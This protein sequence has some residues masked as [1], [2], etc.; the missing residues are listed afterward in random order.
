M[1]EILVILR[2][3]VVEILQIIGFAF[4]IP[5]HENCVICLHHP[6]VHLPLLPHYSQ[7]FLR[8][9]IYFI[10]TSDSSFTYIFCFYIFSYSAYAFQPSQL[11]LCSTIPTGFTFSY[12]VAMTC[13]TLGLFVIILSIYIKNLISVVVVLLLLRLAIANYSLP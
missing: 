7:A 13:L 8:L 12:L 2:D 11:P 3:S 9:H 10:F 4:I 5:F 1:C 6:I